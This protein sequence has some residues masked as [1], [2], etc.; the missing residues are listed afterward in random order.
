MA[1]YNF[2][3]FQIKP[4][5]VGCEGAL[6]DQQTR[7]LDGKMSNFGA[8]SYGIRNA[9]DYTKVLSNFKSKIENPTIP[10]FLQEAEYNKNPYVWGSTVKRMWN[11]EL[12]IM[13][14]GSRYM[15]GAEQPKKDVSD[16]KLSSTTPTDNGVVLNYPAEGYKPFGGRVAGPEGYSV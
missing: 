7:C 6:G 15:N 14:L 10:S 1:K 11:D 5:G 12:R 9:A 16:T 2:S 4:V 3:Y 8:L 13:T